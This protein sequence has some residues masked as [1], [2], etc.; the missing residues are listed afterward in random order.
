MR[1]FFSGGTESASGEEMSWAA[2]QAKLKQ[3][4]DDEDPTHP[5]SDDQLVLELGKQGIDIVRRTAAK[6]RQVLNIPPARRRRKF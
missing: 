5:L 6:Y 3:I 1:M 2:V 4:V